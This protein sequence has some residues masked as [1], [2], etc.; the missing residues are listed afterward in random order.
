MEFLDALV[1][2]DFRKSLIGPLK[3]FYICTL[4]NSTGSGVTLSFFV[5]YLHN[6]RGFSAGFATLL[7]SLSAL[8]SLATGA[9]WGTLTDRFG[10][11]RV[12]LI[13]YVADA[14]AL[15]G[16]A[17]VHTRTQAVVIALALA[18]FGNAGWGPS[19]TLLSRLVPEHHRQRAFGFNFML[20]NLG[21]GFGALVSAAVVDLHHP[22]TFTLLYIVNATMT[23]IAALTFTSLRA[24]GGPV[25]EHRNNPSTAAEGWSTVLRDRRLV[26]YSLAS[27]VLMIGGYGS[28]EAGFSLFVVN[29]LRLPVHF[30]G[31]IFFFNTTTIVVAQLWVLNRI[32]RRSRTRV[33]AV[34]GVLWFI[35]W[36]VLALALALP[37]YVALFSLCAAMVIFAI[38]ETMLSPVGPALVNE[39]APEHLRGRYN[40]AAGL[41]WGISGTFG[42]AITALFFDNNLGNWWPL[43]TGLTA[44][45]GSLLMLNLR[46]RLS[47]SEDGRVE[48][49]TP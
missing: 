26:L 6:V 37:P 1:P 30:I 44:L 32:D 14:A 35:F 8:A 27:L 49:A 48:V 43:C 24:H 11:V 47:P 22:T 36:V 33:L 21:I 10:P 25:T 3:R 42:P 31:I 17:F 34:V 18:V 4:M 46:R 9:W 5:V 13:A 16:W 23:A 40:T 20:I 29:N 28:Q 7:L 38:G 19:S 12:V 15:V 45:V 2:A 39:I 41:T